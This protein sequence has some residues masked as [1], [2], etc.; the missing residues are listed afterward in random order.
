M[1]TSS[2]FHIQQH[3]AGLVVLTGSDGSIYTTEIGKQGKWGLFFY[4]K[5][6]SSMT[7][8]LDKGSIH[9]S[10]LLETPQQTTNINQYRTVQLS[11]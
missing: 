4:F 3:H 8:M 2:Q 10:P 5:G 11:S 9:R 1:R 7:T 6:A